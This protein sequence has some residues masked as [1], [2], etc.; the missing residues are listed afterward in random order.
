MAVTQSFLASKSLQLAAVMTES[1]FVGAFLI[2][3]AFVC[4]ILATAHRTMSLML[5]ILFG[6]SIVMFA[7]SC[8]HL[9]LVIQEIAVTNPPPANNQAQIVLSMLQFLIGELILLWRLWVVWGRKYWITT[10]PILL[11]LSAA[12]LTLSLLSESYDDDDDDAD[13]YNTV[14]PVVLIAGNAALCTSLI[15]GRIWYVRWKLRT[16]E[17]ASVGGSSWWRGAVALVV[18]S[19]ILYSGL[20]IA[21]LI[22][23]YR[24]GSALPVLLDL[25]IPLIGILPTLI[26]V[27]VHS[28]LDN[29]SLPA[30]LAPRDNSDRAS[31]YSLEDGSSTYHYSLRSESKAGHYQMY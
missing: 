26:I 25:E 23:H 4:K 24:K 29:A 5:K 27:L 30:P 17:V 22:L 20:Q 18:E 10:V 11:I 28:H 6:A 19:G 21:S 16:A 7:I 3:V 2:L 9:A 8:A 15:A 31:K 14:V 1:F 12:G 13:Y